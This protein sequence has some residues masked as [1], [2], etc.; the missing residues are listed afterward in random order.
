MRAPV[1]VED[2]VWV[3]TASV[4]EVVP[5]GHRD[6]RRRAETLPEWR[7]AEYLAGR[8]LL[9][10]LLT[11]FH[12]RLADLDCV[13]D[14]RGKPRLRGHPGIGVSISHSGGTVAAALA[15]DRALGV[16]VQQPDRT[17]SPALA[18]RLLRERAAGLADLPAGRAAQ[19][20]AWV[21]TAQEACA[22]A[23]GDGIRARPWSIDVP[24]GAREG[25][26]GEY[27]WVSLRDHS[28]I[29]LSCAFTDRFTDV[30]LRTS[31]QERHP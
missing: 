11:T 9:R 15:V 28:P 2:G 31:P 6:D 7:A 21:W 30:H 12:A 20:L 3:V 13:P 4:T 16:D 14:P 5:S 23:D 17:F 10:E 24:P 1:C 26:W 19:E 18:H 8:G 29:P 22:K 27:R 25:K